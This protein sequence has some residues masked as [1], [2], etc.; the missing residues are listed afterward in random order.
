MEL[1]TI[2][3]PPILKQSSQKSFIVANTL[4]SSYQEIRN[5]HIIPVFI[6]DNEPVISHADFIDVSNEIVHHVFQN[7]TILSPS[8]RLSHPIKGRVPEA[9]N[10][11]ANQ[12][13]EEEKTIYYER[14]A[15]VIEVPTIRDTVSG[16]QLNLTIGGVKSYNLDN[17]YSKKGTDE[18]F[19]IFIGFENKVCTNMCVWSDGFIADLKVRSIHELT[20]AILNLITNYNAKQHLDNLNKFTNYTLTENQFAELI[21]KCRMYNYLPQNAKQEIQQLLFGDTQINSVAKDYYNDKSFC[22]S[23]NGDIDLWRFYNLLTGANKSS[24]ID[25]FLDRGL[26]AYEFT[27]SIVNAL[28]SPKSNWFLN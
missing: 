18:H 6:K 25:T 14:M 4:A 3:P 27:N 2:N 26:N 12:L 22:R 15:F 28:E 21:G 24:Y 5:N 19:K 16:N 17:L 9:K 8:I 1:L 7:E 10:K 11:P 13:L 20:D 23:A